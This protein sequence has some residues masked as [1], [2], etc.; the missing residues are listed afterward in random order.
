M[1]LKIYIII[2][3]VIDTTIITIYQNKIK[4]GIY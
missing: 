2:D 1:Y 4:L 3:I